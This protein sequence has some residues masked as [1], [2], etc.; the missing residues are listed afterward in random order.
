MCK[1]INKG[2]WEVYGE[3]DRAMVYLL[4]QDIRTV[5]DLKEKVQLMGVAGH[6]R[7]AYI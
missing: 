7:A 5:L 6:V 4:V 1:Y 2:L 3:E